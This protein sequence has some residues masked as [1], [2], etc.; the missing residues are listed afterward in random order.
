MAAKDGVGG[1]SKPGSNPP[2]RL[3]LPIS[4]ISLFALLSISLSLS[5]NPA[6]ADEVQAPD[7]FA[8]SWDQR[9]FNLSDFLGSPVVLHI[10]NIENP[11][12][13]ECE[14]SLS[15]QVEELAAL[16]A[17]DTNVQIVT[18]NLRKNPYSIDGRELAQTWWEVNI[19]WPWIEDLDPYP[20]GSK[21]LDY[22]TVRGGSSNPTIA[23]IDREG[24]IGPV[25]HVYRVGEG[26]ED[27]V[28]KAQSLLDDI[29]ELNGTALIVGREASLP[30]GQ[31]ADPEGAAGIFS[32]L[33]TRMENEVS[34]KDVTAFGM[35]LLGIFTSLAPCSIALMI[36]VF[37][38]VMTVRRKD[39]YLRASASTSREGFMIGVAFTL[40]MAVVFFVL[41]LFISQIGVFFRDSKIFDLLAGV[42]MVLLGI[43]SF[44][45]LG[46]IIEPV[47][48]RIRLH[49][50]AESSVSDE[51]I[52]EKKSLLQKAVELSL[53][54][55][56]YSAFIG[57][58]TLGIF[59][60]LGW[61]PCAL[62]MVMPVLIWLASQDV[63]PLV[64]GTMLFF[65]G[66][67][68]G[69][70]II[71]ITTFSRMVGGRIGEKYV[72]VGEWTSKIFGLLV[73]LVGLVYAARYFGYLLW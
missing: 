62:S 32:S 34:R 14:K 48:D 9:S 50:A 60:A 4:I 28:Q 1:Q 30:A 25:Y 42:I 22:W 8:T 24:R 72:S 21:Y 11:L 68:H 6:L 63:A 19:T 49:R 65:F 41:G 16:K 2:P 61:A 64:G 33:W 45:P 27:G 5:I 13:I 15:G 47:T 3:I 23:L 70:P 18:L 52:K 69:V 7:F 40:G 46:E 31:D 73:I 59:F 37:S 56:R 10:T 44:K 36:A 66:I 67:G 71:P 20:I 58:F 53:N 51:P 29:Q 55:F 35:F 17:L 38:Y 43:S 54:L 12:C 26:I 39:E 57:A